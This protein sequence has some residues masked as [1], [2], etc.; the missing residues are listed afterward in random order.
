MKKFYYLLL[1]IAT[2][3][4]AQNFIKVRIIDSDDQKPIA[5]ARVILQNQI[6]Y[7]NDDGYLLLPESS[8]KLQISAP[9]YENRILAKASEYISLKPKI[10]EINEILMKSVDIEKIFKDVLKNYDKAYYVEPSLFEI[11]YK[12]KGYRNGNLY[13]ATIAD[14][15]WLSKDNKY[16]WKQ[17]FKRNYNDI[18]QI[19]YQFVKRV[20]VDKKDTINLPYSNEFRHEIVGQYFLNFEIDKLQNLMKY[21]DA[22][23][24]GFIISET[25]GIQ[26]IKFDIISTSLF[27][28]KGFLDYDVKNKAIAYIETNF[29]QDKYPIMDKISIDGE[30]YQMKAGDVKRVNSFYL[31]EGKYIPSLFSIS[32]DNFIT[33]KNGERSVTKSATQFIFKSFKKSEINELEPRIDFEGKWW[34]NVPK[35]NYVQTNLLTKE[36]Q[37]F[38]KENN[39]EN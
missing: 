19:Q 3:A 10:Q 28:I 37:E 11:N 7:S 18:L 17:G 30:K 16:N 2:I 39:I 36:E 21:K 38:L 6:L 32:T 14:G 33:I 20:D 13:A 31:N 4:N 25:D 24:S 1:F 5:N 12:S 15:L 23:V 27:H 8:V 26:K 34:K 9:N 22:K 35:Y 29:Y